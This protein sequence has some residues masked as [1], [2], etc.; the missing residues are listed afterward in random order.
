MALEGIV[1]VT[2]GIFAR[3]KRDGVADAIK[4]KHWSNQVGDPSKKRAIWKNR[5]AAGTQSPYVVYGVLTDTLISQSTGPG[6]ATTLAGQL[7]AGADQAVQ[8]RQ[9]QIQ[10]MCYTKKDGGK[11]ETA[12]IFAAETVDAAM[13]NGKLCFSEG[14]RF[15]TLTRQPDIEASD[16]DENVVIGLQYQI[17]YE[18]IINMSRQLA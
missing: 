1:Q 5:A 3:L 4:A 6:K 12:A 18:H 2:K 7:V 11:D 14:T 13:T 10:F 8:L 16:D 9:A 17:D 15:V